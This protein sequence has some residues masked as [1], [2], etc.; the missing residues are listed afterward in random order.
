MIPSCVAASSVGNTGNTVS[1]S[2]NFV[3]DILLLAVTTL[4]FI[5]SPVTF[6]SSSSTFYVYF[7]KNS[8]ATVKPTRCDSVQTE[9]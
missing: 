5:S 3:V 9:C 6:S 2:L 7:F 8:V 1:P 4:T